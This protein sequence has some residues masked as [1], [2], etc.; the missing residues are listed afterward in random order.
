MYQ[1]I[2]AFLICFAMASCHNDRTERRYQED[3]AWFQENEKIKILATTSIIADLVRTIGG[4]HVD[5]LALIP[6]ELDP[7]SY[8][9]VK[10]DGEKFSFSQIIFYN[11]LGLEHT[12]SFLA[13]LKN[14][15]HAVALAE[16]IFSTKKELLLFYNG[17]PDP[18]V[19]MDLKLWSE[20]IPQVV[21]A[22]CIKDPAHAEEYLAGGEL[23]RAELLNADRRVRKIMADVPSSKRFL[24]TSHDAFH[25]FARAYLSQENDAVVWHER[26]LAPEG[27]A[28]ES[29]ISSK[30]IRAVIHYLKKH[31]ISIIFPESNIN[32]ASLRKVVDCSKEFG[33][34]VLLA[35][36]PLYSDAL[37]PKNSEAGTHIGMVEYNA[38]TIANKLWQQ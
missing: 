11:G 35:D 22:L 8:Q 37:G 12:P 18:H 15:P 19:W 36:T 26:F 2:L 20:A 23:C 9:L 16:T 24:V 17:Q 6:E 21:T 31:D 30:E 13:P 5:V 38:K 25:Y 29:Q 7:H 34:S 14:H 33:L 27:L 1:Y 32:A 10:G 4:S 3:R 28:P